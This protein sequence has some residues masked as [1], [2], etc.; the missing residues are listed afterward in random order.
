MAAG[1]AAASSLLPRKTL[2]RSGSIAF[3][4]ILLASLALG[5][6]H[7]GTVSKAE[8]SLF[9]VQLRLAQSGDPSGEFYVGEMYQQGLGT[10]RNLEKAH[11]W[12]ERSARKGNL[13]AKEKL[14]NWSKLLQ[15]VEQAKLQK[16]AAARAAI[17][18]K[19]QAAAR[20]AAMAKEQAAARA[21]EIAQA[22][23]LARKRAAAQRARQRAE[24]EAAARRLQRERAAALR[25]R[26][27]AQERARAEA[28][29]RAAAIA[30]AKTHR[31]APAK[32]QD[33]EPRV[34]ESAPP[35]KVKHHALQFSPDPCKGP[36]AKFLS[37]CQ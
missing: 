21:E 35:R 30:I 5:P 37:T 7:A 3:T 23:A 25:A 11:K 17:L 34:A 10:P 15:A 8:A 1:T 9:Q 27:L 26:Q 4:G 31:P 33:R 24:A 32:L 22:E 6:A 2:R 20:A 14:A 29:Q 19:R 18:A 13:E 12:Y 16:Q 28:R 36:A